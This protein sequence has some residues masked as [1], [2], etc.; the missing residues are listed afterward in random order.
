LLQEAHRL[1]LTLV[2]YNLRT[3][4]LLLRT[5]ADET[6]SHGGVIFVDEKTIAPSDIGALLKLAAA[7]GHAHWENC[8]IYLTK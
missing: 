1:K 7:H 2:T 8:I 5:W 6:P 3:I 4:P